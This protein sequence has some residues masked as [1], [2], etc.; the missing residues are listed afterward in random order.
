MMMSS[1]IFYGNFELED[2]LSDL[3]S[4]APVQR[5][6][7][8]HQGGAIF[9]VSPNAG[10]SRFEHSIGVMPLPALSADRVDY[11]IRDLYHFG[12]TDI[13]EVHDFLNELGVQDG[14]IGISEN[15]NIYLPI[16]GLLN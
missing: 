8:I 13:V 9:L 2:I 6:K 3:I 4:S 1:D 10:H 5:L 7:N 16:P 14:K 12:L 15:P 11:T